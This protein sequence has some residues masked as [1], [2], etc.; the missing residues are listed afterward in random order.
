MGQRFWGRNAGCFLTV[1]YLAGLI[2]GGF[3]LHLQLT[4]EA[5]SAKALLDGQFALWGT[6]DGSFEALAA[7]GGRIYLAGL[8]LMVLA[9]CFGLWLVGQPFIL[10]VSAAAGVV[11]GCGGMLLIGEDF[12]GIWFLLLWYLPLAAG[13][14][15]IFFPTAKAG[16]SLTGLYRA[17]ESGGKRELRQYLLYALR[18]AGIW[19]LIC[20]LAVG[21]FYWYGRGFLAG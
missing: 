5:R 15:M 17:E 1:S 21:C 16:L 3:M 12:H 7:F 20:A 19:A 10:L 2:C 18:Q 8:A 13:Y 4:E 11:C 14:F 6:L 9:V